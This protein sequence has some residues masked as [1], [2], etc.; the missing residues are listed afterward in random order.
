LGPISVLKFNSEYRRVIVLFLGEK[1]NQAHSSLLFLVTGTRIMPFIAVTRSTSIFRS[2]FIDDGSSDI[3]TFPAH[4]IGVNAIS[5]SPAMSPGSLTNPG[6]QP[7]QQQGQGQQSQ[8]PQQQ[9]YQRKFASA[10][11]DGVVRIWNYK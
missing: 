2:E 8:Q 7:Q 3:D 10:G 6:S 1:R 4:A 11:C 9:Q 5:W